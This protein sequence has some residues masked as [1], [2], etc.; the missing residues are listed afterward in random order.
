MFATC[1]LATFTGSELHFIEPR[2]SQAKA[3]NTAVMFQKE[4]T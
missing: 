4:W 3:I 1:E 2:A